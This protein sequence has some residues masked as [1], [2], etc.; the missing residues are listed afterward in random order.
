MEED[1]KGCYSLVYIITVSDVY[2]E[3]FSLT[4]WLERNPTWEL[5]KF[6]PIT[7]ADKANYFI[8]VPDYNAVFE[9]NR[10]AS[11]AW[12]RRT[13]HPLVQ[14]RKKNLTHVL[15]GVTISDDDTW[16]FVRFGFPV[17][18]EEY[19]SYAT[20]GVKHMFADT[21]P[22]TTPVVIWKKK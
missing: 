7:E 22:P 17:V 9:P 1:M 13:V 10:V 5:V 14:V 3:D 15:D 11:A 18:R 20:V 4:E 19:W 6:A 16:K 2:G 21:A 8:S 12:P